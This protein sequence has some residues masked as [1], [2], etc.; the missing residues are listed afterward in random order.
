MR[1]W[2]F[3]RSFSGVFVC[4]KQLLGNKSPDE[5]HRVFAHPNCETIDSDSV[6]SQCT[7]RSGDHPVRITNNFFERLATLVGCRRNSM[8]IK[9]VVGIL[10]MF[11]ISRKFETL[12]WLLGYHKESFSHMKFK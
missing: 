3:V 10:E 2:F 6:G 9:S 11:Y 7:D 8:K 5:M 4:R 12:W 1:E